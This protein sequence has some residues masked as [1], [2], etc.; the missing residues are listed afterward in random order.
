MF[1]L[2]C[3]KRNTFQPSKLILYNRTYDNVLK[4]VSCKNKLKNK[5]KYLVSK[6]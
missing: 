1:I 5:N 3:F 4:F 2:E 6:S